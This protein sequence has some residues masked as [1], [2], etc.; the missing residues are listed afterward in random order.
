MHS[1]GTRARLLLGT[2]VGPAN[3]SEAGGPQLVL[4]GNLLDE[5]LI[6]SVAQGAM[7]DA[8]AALAVDAS[9]GS[10]WTPKALIHASM[11]AFMVR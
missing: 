11:G 1:D 3:S 8:E 5:R 9:Y 10:A 6:S 7:K 4:R 2:R